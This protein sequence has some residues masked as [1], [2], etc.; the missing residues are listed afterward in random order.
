VKLKNFEFEGC[1]KKKI[2][3]YKWTLPKNKKPK[4]VLQIAHGMAEH[5]GRYDAF[6]QALNKAGF[7][8]YANDH[9]GHGKT[10]GSIEECG[11][12]AEKN[13]WELVRDDMYELTKLI[14]KENKKVP[15]FL[16]GHS[17]GSFFTRSYL[18]KYA[19]ELKGAILSGT[20]GDPGLLGAIGKIIASIEKKIKGPKAKSHLMDKLSF[21]AFNNSFKPNRTEFDWLSTVDEEVD[22]YINDPYCGNI[23]TTSYFYQL[24]GALKELNNKKTIETMRK[25]LP[26]YIF[27]GA[28]CPVGTETRGVTEIFNKYV[29]AGIQDVSLKFYGQSRHETLNEWNKEEVYQDVINWLDSK[30]K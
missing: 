1:D 30:Y 4:A 14:K 8:V 6:A 19:D 15:I 13:G 27:S 5:A 3:G 29:K 24:L 9:R 22:K 10:A 20:A 28:M 2:T 25:D 23:H 21:G 16:L 7:V 18:L 12:F 11:F 26:I 17:M